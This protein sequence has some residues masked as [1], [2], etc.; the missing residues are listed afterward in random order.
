MNTDSTAEASSPI[1][2]MLLADL[3]DDEVIIHGFPAISEGNMEPTLTHVNL[4]VG[5][6]TDSQTQAVVTGLVAVN[7]SIRM[8]TEA[9]NRVFIEGKLVGIFQLT[10]KSDYEGQDT[11]LIPKNIGMGLLSVVIGA[12]RG[13]MYTYLK[14]T[15]LRA[16]F[17]PPV[18]L[19]EH[20][21]QD[22]PVYIQEGQPLPKE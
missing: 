14:S 13:V 12:M 5:V 4:S 1:P 20:M 3:R 15:P 22:M 2:Q 11:I 16:L 8:L 6:M 19:T 21:N 9:D 17:I 10:N 18:N 7:L